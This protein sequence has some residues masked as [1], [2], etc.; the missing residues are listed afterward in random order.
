[1]PKPIEVTAFEGANA[2]SYLRAVFEAYRTGRVVLAL[3]PGAG[4]QTVPGT[5]VLDRQ[6]FEEDP[7]WFEDRLDLIHTD[8]AAQIA[9][10]S[11][12]TGRP[13][14]LLLSHR[15]LSDVVARINEAMQVDDSIRE[16]IGVPVTFSFGFGR[17]RAVAAAGGKAYLPPNGFDPAEIGRMLSA[18]EINAISAVPTLWRVLLA[19]PSVIGT[20]GAD[21]RWI[22]IGSQYMSGQEKA[23]L[24]ALFPNA[25]IVQHY[26]LTEASRSTLLD[27]SATT[28]DALESV[29]AATGDCA[30][31]ISD[32]GLIRVR[33]PHLAMGVVGGAGVKPITDADGWLTTADRGQIRDG[34]LYYEGRID[35]LINCGG[36]KIDPTRFE[37]QLGQALGLSEGIAVGRIADSLRGEQVLIAVAQDSA[38]HADSLQKVAVEIAES[39]GLTRGALSFRTVADI[40]K[41]ATGKVK[42]AELP[43]LPDLSAAP[44]EAS[45]D[46]LAQ[47]A[48]RAAELQALWAE[49]LGVPE[50]SIHESF[51]DLG[52]DSLSALTVIMRMEALGLDPDTAR[53][54]FDGKTIAE[55]T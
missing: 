8:A 12:T 49:V 25:K 2:R 13:K 27:I 10:S 52:G 46:A 20:A 44:A 48:S 28:G 34:L 11:G 23:E 4:R 33:G 16:Y 42:R 17:A 53:M 30:V 47:P 31:S 19:N 29:G 39:Y 41:T 18:G 36:V 40:P 51:Y 35:E 15:A 54:I 50:V 24:K 37:Q 1:M 32:E 14:A 26:G 55:I 5:K 38:A 7:G 21:L 43:D 22:E 3:P 45:A 9:F 6:S